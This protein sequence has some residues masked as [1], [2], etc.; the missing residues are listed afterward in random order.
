MAVREEPL[1]WAAAQ[2][3]DPRGLFAAYPFVH[4]VTWH[5]THLSAIERPLIFAS[6]QWCWLGD[7]LSGFDDWSTVS[8][9]GVQRTSTAQR[10]ATISRATVSSSTFTSRTNRPTA[11]VRSSDARLRFSRRRPRA[12][13]VPAIMAAGMDDDHGWLVRELVPGRLLSEAIA[14]GQPFDRV[15]S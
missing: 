2:P 1:Y 14:E 3:A 6:S 9:K 8:R 13:A 5:A 10:A 11:I 12:C 4:D 7:A 15:A